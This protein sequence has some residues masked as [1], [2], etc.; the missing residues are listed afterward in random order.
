[1]FGFSKV[2]SSLLCLYKLAIEVGR[3]LDCF[4]LFW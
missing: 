3:V 4:V 1:M 2:V